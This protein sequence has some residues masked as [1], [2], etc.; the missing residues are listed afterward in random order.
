MNGTSF[1][2]HAQAS[3][4]ALSLTLETWQSCPYMWPADEVP[5]RR[6]KD[7]AM[8]TAEMCEGGGHDCSHAVQPPLAGFKLRILC[9]ASASCAYIYI[10]IIPK[11]PSAICI[12]IYMY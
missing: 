9:Y 11:G 5:A 7:L 1:Q 2:A 3:I 4:V 12:Y 6:S 8:A 10:Y